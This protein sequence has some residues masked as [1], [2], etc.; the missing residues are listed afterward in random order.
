MTRAQ[1]P[2]RSGRSISEAERH[3]VQVKI[4]LRPAVA[5]RLRA[6]AKAARCTLGDLIAAMLWGEDARRD[7]A[8]LAALETKFPRLSSQLAANVAKP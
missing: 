8:A 1:T 7:R 3:S 2:V 5:R 4:R 6:T